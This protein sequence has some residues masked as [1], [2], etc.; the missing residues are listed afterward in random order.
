M[1]T[2]LICSMISN[3][4]WL[5]RTIVLMYLYLLIISD[6]CLS[7]ENPI[8]LSIRKAWY[9]IWYNPCKLASSVI[10]YSPYHESALYLIVNICIAGIQIN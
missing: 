5:K 8:S 2:T 9:Q 1:I 10:W 3:L 7:Y 6:K 4:E